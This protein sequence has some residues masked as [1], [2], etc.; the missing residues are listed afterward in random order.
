MTRNSGWE[1]EVCLGSGVSGMFCSFTA[2]VT[3]QV[4]FGN[5]GRAALFG[6]LGRR[7]EGDGRLPRAQ[8]RSRLWFD[9]F[10]RQVLWLKIASSAALGKNHFKSESWKSIVIPPNL[11]INLLAG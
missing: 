9:F 6:V 4:V 11:C 2:V 3:L 8:G 1:V 5:F 7:R 10:R